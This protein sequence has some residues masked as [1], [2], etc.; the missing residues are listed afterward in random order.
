MNCISILLGVLSAP[1]A[2]PEFFIK[3][4]VEYQLYS[5]TYS[6]EFEFYVKGDAW[7]VIIDRKI[8]DSILPGPKTLPNGKIMEI[9][10]PPGRKPGDKI[11]ESKSQLTIMGGESVAEHYQLETH[12][13]YYLGDPVVATPS[14][15]ARPPKPPGWDIVERVT[16]F[17]GPVPTESQEKVMPYLWLAFGS[18]PYFESLKTNMLVPFY[19]DWAGRWGRKDYRQEA[20]WRLADTV[21]RLPLEVTYLNPGAKWERTV[22][23]NVVTTNEVLVPY[24]PPYDKGFKNGQ[25]R[26]TAQTNIGDLTLPLEFRFDELVPAG[27][28]AVRA[29]RTVSGKVHTLYSYCPKKDLR[30]TFAPNS[31]VTDERIRTNQIGDLAMDTARPAG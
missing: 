14:P 4:N 22:V 28:G 21:P 3:G 25:Y 19:N 26:V 20:T 29:V 12:R 1:A 2:E 11:S 30:L 16:L 23:N 27:G 15:T 31:A 5:E 9:P 7:R 13:S 18:R 24:A 8:P 6:R 17:S 10:L